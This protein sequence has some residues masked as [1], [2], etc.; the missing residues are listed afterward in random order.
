MI[1]NG[2]LSPPYRVYILDGHKFVTEILTHRLNSDPNIEV[3]G[4]GNKGGLR[5]LQAKK[6]PG[7]RPGDLSHLM[8]GNDLLSHG[9][10][11]TIIGA[12]QFHF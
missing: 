1:N 8:P 3:V 10:F 11:H 4:I 6:S 5:T 7:Q 2:P 12:E 9:G